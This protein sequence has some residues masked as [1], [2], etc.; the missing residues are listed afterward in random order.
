MA[1]VLDN[2]LGGA[3]RLVVVDTETTGVYSKDRVVELALVTLSPDGEVVD[4]WDSLVQPG[5]AVSATHIHGITAAMVT[6]APT[7]D[8]VA[9]D[10]A[11]RLEGAAVAAHNLAFDHRMLKAEFARIGGSLVIPA[12]VDTLLATGTKLSVACAAHGVTIG[13]QHRARDDALAT[14]ALLRVV[15]SRCRPGAPAAAPVG[16]RRSGRVL[17]REDM[18]PVELPDPP[19]IADLAARL[20]YDGVEPAV[21]A[22]LEVL[23][24]AVE[25]LHLDRDERAE[26]EEIARF[27]GLGEAQVGQAHRRFVNELIDS[28]L[29]DH[30]LTPDEYDALVRVGA[31]L[32]VE[33]GRIEARLRPYQERSGMVTV[34]SGMSVVFT[35][36]HPLYSRS[37]LNS[38]AESVG[39]VVQKGVTKATGLVAAMEPES[40]SGKAGKARRYGI[41]IVSIDDLLDFVPGGAIM[42]STVEGVLKVITCPDC[43]TTWTVEAVSGD[44][45]RS[46]AATVRRHR[47]RARGA[48]V[49]RRCRQG[50]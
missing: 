46:A 43:L 29:A 40:N 25:D 13:D 32:E 22:Y 39:L 21:L 27:V 19:V 45:S 37:Q 20:A 2:L 38:H 10:V 8:D 35:G 28:A 23:G 26:L 50:W 4:V 16:L 47:R 6:D 41:P 5:R 11:I 12:G 18:V 48:I 49:S 30:V 31:A 9:G 14:A 24:L 17:R 7:F 34:E 3:D 42:A 44:V 1:A 33:P 15:A 36:D